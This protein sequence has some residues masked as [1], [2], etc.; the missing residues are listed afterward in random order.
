MHVPADPDDDR[1]ALPHP[2][3]HRRASGFTQSAGYLIA[4]VGPFAVGAIYEGTGGWTW[5][6][7]LLLVL[8]LPQILLGRYAARPAYI[9]DQLHAPPPT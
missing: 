9:E 2:R 4:A 3:R 8:T 1:A 6:L 5:P 7:V